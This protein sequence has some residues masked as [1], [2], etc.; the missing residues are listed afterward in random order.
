M[1]DA[2][3]TKDDPW[4]L[5]TPPGTSEYTMYRDEAADPPRIVCQVGKTQLSYRLSAIDDL[6][7]ML[8][9]AGDW[10]ALGSADENKQ[11][12]ALARVR[13]LPA[14]I[15]EWV[16][17]AVAGGGLVENDADMDGFPPHPREPLAPGPAGASRTPLA[18][19]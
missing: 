16:R 9:A 7:A 18:T 13:A 4:V 6:H 2:A 8:V 17:S 15:S 1:S 11:L 14:S 3:G 19:S 5:K 12:G 10:V